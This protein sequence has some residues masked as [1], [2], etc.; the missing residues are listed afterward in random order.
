M[1][2]RSDHTR[3]EIRDM[4]LQAAEQ[5]VANE[6]SSALSTRRVAHAI[7]YTVGTLYLVFRNLDDLILQVNAKTL[8]DLQTR[9]VEAITRHGDGVA[10]VLALGGTYLRFAL[11]RPHPFTLVFEHRLPGDE[12][13]PVWYQERV[14][15]VFDLLQQSLRAVLTEHSEADVASA[16]RVIWGG[17]HGICVLALSRRISAV[18]AELPTE[19]LVDS[20]IRNYLAGLRGAKATT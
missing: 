2:R 17:V 8:D 20:L 6:G 16:A 1:A 13:V 12:P 19:A 15:R 7:G 10:R 9:M 14:T 11:E 5:I 4:A 18:G 3:D